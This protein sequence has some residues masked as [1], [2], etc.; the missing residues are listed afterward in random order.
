MKCEWPHPQ[1]KLPDDDDR[2]R[3]G[4]V[5]KN[6]DMQAKQCSTSTHVFAGRVEAEDGVVGYGPSLVVQK[7]LYRYRIVQ[8]HELS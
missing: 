8:I 2:M 4:G 3:G 5:E 6:N 7:C 1:N